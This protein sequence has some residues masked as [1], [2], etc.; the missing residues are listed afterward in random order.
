MKE[1]SATTD[2]MRAIIDAPDYGE[3]VYAALLGKVIGVYLGRPFEG[4]NHA[5]IDAELGEIRSYVHERLSAPLLVTDDDI[6]GT[7]T[8]IRAAAD[9]GRGYETTAQDVA[10]AWLNYLL[11]N[12]SVLWWG[13]VSYS[14][15]HTAY[16]RLREGHKPP[17]SGS[18]ALNGKTVAEQ[19]GGQIF[20]DGWALIAPGSPEL[21]ADLAT[22]AASVSHDGEAIQAARVVAALESEAFV[23][24]DINHL[25]DVAVSLIRA[26]TDT[27]RVIA[28]VRRWHASGADWREAR[29]LLDD[30]YGYS[31]YKGL[32][33]VVPNL[34]L[35]VLAL[36]HGNGDFSESLM[37]VNTSGWDTDCN[38]GNLGCLL[39]IIGG[40]AGIE[41]GYDWRGPVADRIYVPNADV[42]SGI[43]DVLNESDRIVAMARDASHLP[44]L[45]RGPRYRFTYPGSMQGF[46]SADGTLTNELLPVSSVRRGLRLHGSAA[47]TATTPTFLPPEAREMPGYDLELSPALYSG[48]TVNVSL[49]LSGLGPSPTARIVLKHYGAD[50][51]LHLKSGPEVVLVDGD[52]HLS[53]VTPELGGYPIVMIGVSLTEVRDDSTI[54]L[55]SLDWASTPTTDLV[56]GTAGE[57]WKRAWVSSLG[58]RKYTYDD[59]FRV[60]GN[61]G[62]G[63]LLSGG[64][65]WSNYRATARYRLRRA[66]RF[67]LAARVAGLERYYL[68]VVSDEGT[69]SI[70]KRLNGVDTVLA[71]GSTN[72]QEDEEADLWIEV[73][74]YRIRAGK[75]GTQI[76]QADDL[77]RPLAAGGIALFADRGYAECL[78]VGIQAIDES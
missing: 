17:L 42:G 32:V 64:A 9:S 67:G 16:V 55:E 71:E 31:K 34:G 15:E 59:Y 27:A 58:L 69:L 53:F 7:L 1:I 46:T 47:L 13:G 5:R 3:R 24:T 22:R 41:S 74:G 44:A 18:I 28:D 29:Q 21:A 33:P 61:Y 70:V 39:G 14:T 36:L 66:K 50:D 11:E 19:I 73:D 57:M 49:H 77:T 45:P 2:G 75:D 78:K 10:D 26:D 30:R 76:A 62:A 65:D 23:S 54:H 12:R 20:I 72:W 43:T 38:S 8:F 56:P 48:Q 6:S 60:H 51:L 25:L 52:N 68:A 40:L 37:I 35:I 63:M 4:W